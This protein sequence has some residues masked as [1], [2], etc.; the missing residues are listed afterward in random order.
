MYGYAVS[1]DGK[2]LLINDA[3]DATVPRVALVT[4]WTAGLK[5]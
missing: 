5:K 4:N 1:P 3:G 2:R